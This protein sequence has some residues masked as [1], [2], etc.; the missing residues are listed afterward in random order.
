MQLTLN[1][2]RKL[3]WVPRSVGTPGRQWSGYAKKNF[4]PNYIN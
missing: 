1:I 3:G 4:S 2:L